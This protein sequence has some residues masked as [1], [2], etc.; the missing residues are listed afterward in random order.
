[1]TMSAVYMSVRICGKFFLSNLT[2]FKSVVSSDIDS[3]DYYML[4]ALAIL[5]GPPSFINITRPAQFFF[6]EQWK[7]NN[8]LW[9]SSPLFIY[10]FIYSF[11]LFFWGGVLFLTNSSNR[12]HYQEGN[13]ERTLY[14]DS[15]RL[16]G[17][18]HFDAFF[19]LWNRCARSLDWFSLSH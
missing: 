8:R 5:S 17:E 10:L 7:N 16:E 9:F 2:Y 15:I 3:W 14:G 12:F 1:M 6:S 11:F 19:W 18:E 13:G 4:F